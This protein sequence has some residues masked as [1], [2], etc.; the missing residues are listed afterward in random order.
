MERERERE[1]ERER[2]RETVNCVN[3][4]CSF[5]KK[6]EVVLCVCRVNRCSG[7]SSLYH[8]SGRYKHR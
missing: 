1:T 2:E 7:T 5:E 6:V 8:S 4:Q 3:Y